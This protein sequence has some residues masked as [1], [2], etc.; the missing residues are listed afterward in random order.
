MITFL[1]SLI[2]RDINLDILRVQGYRFFCNKLWNA[3]RFALD[4]LKD[5]EAEELSIVSLTSSSQQTFINGVNQ[6]V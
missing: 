1:S 6:T 3:V 4:Y 5:F 2:A